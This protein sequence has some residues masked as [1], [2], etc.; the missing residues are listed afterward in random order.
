[1]SN[2]SDFVIENG[3]LKKYTGSGG[4]VVIPA[5]CTEVYAGAF[6]NAFAVT[7]VTI[8]EGVTVIGNRADDAGIAGS[9]KALGRKQQIQGCSKRNRSLRS[10][11]IHTGRKTPH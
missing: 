5:G 9:A 2:A 1:M 8:P 11:I 10:E 4:D 6:N 7:S 3:V